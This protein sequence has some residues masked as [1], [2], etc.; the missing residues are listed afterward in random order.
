MTTDNDG[1]FTLL[2]DT[3]RPSHYKIEL[4]PDLETGTFMGEISID[5]LV[6]K[7][8]NEVVFKRD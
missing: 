8:T 4:T 3:V 2:P 6:T 5:V 1:R 7:V